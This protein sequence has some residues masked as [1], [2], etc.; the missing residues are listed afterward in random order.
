VSSPPPTTP[1]EATATTVLHHR[2]FYQWCLQE[3]QGMV[4]VLGCAIFGCLF[5]FGV[6]SGWI[7]GEYG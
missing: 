4:W 3:C 2:S 7:V 6:G 5:G 1:P